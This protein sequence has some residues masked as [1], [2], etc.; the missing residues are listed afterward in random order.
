MIS[1]KLE[2]VRGSLAL[3]ISDLSHYTVEEAEGFGFPPINRIREQGPLQHG[4]TDRGYRLQKRQIQC[5]LMLRAAD[6]ASHFARRQELVEYLNP[7]SDLPVILR[8]TQPDGATVRQIDGY[9]TE[10]PQFGKKDARMYQMQRAG[11]RLSCPDPAWYDPERKSVR[12]MG[13]GGGTSFKFPMAVPWT[14]GGLDVDSAIAVDYQGTW[15]EYPE[16]VITGPLSDARIENLE[17]GEVLDF[18]GD[19]IDEG[20]FYTIDLRYAYKT[21]LDSSGANQI[22]KL[23]PASDLATWHLQPGGANSIAFSGTSAGVAT[24]VILRWYNRYLGI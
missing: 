8:F 4:E 9:C 7:A 6:W 1:G 5:T 22:A 23:T 16:I 13:S 15:Q 18:D 12:A 21:V 19:T 17:T 2:I 3:D 24:S 10:G 14:F 11:F 20:D